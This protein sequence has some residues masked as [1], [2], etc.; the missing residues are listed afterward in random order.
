V[1]PW[2]ASAPTTVTESTVTVV[3]DVAACQ[4][5]I[6]PA[7]RHA[8]PQA[9]IRPWCIRRISAAGWLVAHRPKGPNPADDRRPDSNRHQ[10]HI[11]RDSP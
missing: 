3:T 11:G 10:L 4:P 5:G 6:P 1:P 8:H 9:D 7:V 2:W